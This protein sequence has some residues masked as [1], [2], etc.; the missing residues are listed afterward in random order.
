MG[1]AD[2]Q[3]KRQTQQLIRGLNSQLPVEEGMV[4]PVLA[5]GH[6]GVLDGEGVGR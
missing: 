1:L 3:A 6:H 5:Y 4:L 2:M